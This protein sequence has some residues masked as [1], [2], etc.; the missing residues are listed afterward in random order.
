MGINNI[1]DFVES[2]ISDL[3]LN[4]SAHDAS[5][6]LSFCQRKWLGFC[7]TCLLLSNEINWACYSRLSFGYYK[8]SAL[9]WMFRHSKIN[10]ELLFILSVAHILSVYGLTEGHLIFDDTDNERS[11]NALFIHGL[12]KQKDKKSGGYFLGQNIMFMLLVTP[13]VTLVVGFKFYE[14]DPSW[15]AWKKNDTQLR[16]KKVDK[17]H[18][19]DEVLR[20]FVKY[21]TKSELSIQLAGAFKQHYPNFNIISIMADCF[22]GTKDWTLGMSSHYPKAQII[23]QLKSNQVINYQ[24]KD[25]ALSTYFNRRAAISSTT[26]IRGGKTVP[27]YYSSVI[28]KV[29]AHGTKRL[30]IA[31]KYHGEA[32]FRYVFATD[33][34]WMPHHIIAVYSLRW[35]VE[36]F[37]ADW[38]KYEGWAVL[39]KHIGYEGSNMSLILSLLFDHCLMLHP[40]QQARIKD[41]LPTATVGSLREKCIQQHLLKT[42]ECIIN[43]QNPKQRLKEFVQYIEQIYLL[44]DSKKHL[45]GRKFAFT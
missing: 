20:D 32:E 27:I 44:R 33:M 11:K 36:V 6:R 21:P 43:D 41:N 10:F 17:A 3:S 7:L 40:E 14:N 5:Y 25:Y 35:L 30:I 16:T 34:S 13:K 9:S 37:I 26:V 29:Q 18:R 45:S 15:Q 39:T 38:K 12:G 22:F 28:A 31:Y 23:S 8:I 1:S 24:N 4:L 2:Y 42:I 19:P